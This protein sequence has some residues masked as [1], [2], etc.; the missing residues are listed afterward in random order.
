MHSSALIVQ[1]Y[2]LRRSCGELF[3]ARIDPCV[4]NG[5]SAITT[6]FPI[7]VWIVGFVYLAT[8]VFSRV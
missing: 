7:N 8:V 6:G 1:T 3:T 2:L 5:G 4:H